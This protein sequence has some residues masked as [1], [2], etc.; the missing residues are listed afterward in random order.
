MSTGWHAIVWRRRQRKAERIQYV[1][2]MDL[3]D[4][5][6][7]VRLIVYRME[8]DGIEVRWEG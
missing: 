3:K 7:R 5:G 6:G 4:G 1:K 2:P 8:V